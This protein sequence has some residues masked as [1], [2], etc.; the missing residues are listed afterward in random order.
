MSDIKKWKF[1]IFTFNP[2]TKEVGLIERLVTKKMHE[3]EFKKLIRRETKN[4][5]NYCYW[6]E[7]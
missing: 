6:V 4:R 3:N 1:K 2:K 7:R 5:K